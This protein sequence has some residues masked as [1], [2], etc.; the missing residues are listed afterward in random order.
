M[1]PLNWSRAPQPEAVTDWPAL[2]N[3]FDAREVLHVT[4]GSVLT[5]KTSSG[6]KRFYDRIFAVLNSNT[7]AYAANLEKHFSKHLQPFTHSQV[8]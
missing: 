7:E 6:Q 3:Q 5:E 4:F 2:L 1:S 8:E